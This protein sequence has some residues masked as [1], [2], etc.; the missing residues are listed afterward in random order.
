MKA[1]IECFP[2]AAGLNSPTFAGKIFCTAV[3]KD[4]L[5]NTVETRD[6]VVYAESDPRSRKRTRKFAN[7]S[8]REGNGEKKGKR[9]QDRIVRL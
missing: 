4:I 2:L 1:N 8:K 3:T 9:P 5:L 6:R 7:L